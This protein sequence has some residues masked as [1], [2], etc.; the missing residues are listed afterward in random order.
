VADGTRAK[1]L[2]EELNAPR[3]DMSAALV[4]MQTSETDPDFTTKRLL[5]KPR[6]SFDPDCFTLRELAAM[7][8]LAEIFREA[9]ADHMSEVSHVPGEPWHKVFKVDKRPQALIPYALVL[10]SQPDS[11]TKE[12]ADQIDEE[13]RE[14]RALFK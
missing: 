6:R 7:E 4:L 9:T 11:I 2:F 3:P 8:R 1:D 5:I 14:A 12:Q 10:D 13:E